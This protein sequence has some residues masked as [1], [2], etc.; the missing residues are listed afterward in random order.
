MSSKGKGV[1]SYLLGW[2]GGLITLFAFKD[3]NR[4]DVFHACQAI[5]ISVAQLAA[6]IVIAVISAVL[7]T[8]TG[9]S[10]GFVGWIIDILYC[11]LVILGLVKVLNDE[12]DPKLPV[13]GDIT[14]KIFEKKINETPE[15]APAAPTA[16]FDP[17]TGQ[18]INQPQANFD[19]NTGQPINQPTPESNMGPDPDAAPEEPAQEEAPA[20]AA[21]PAEEL[22]DDSD[23]TI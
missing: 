21:E 10:L 8:V 13:V 14:E 17:N 2:V 4:K 19:P 11:I 12:A 7:A 20:D 6:T 1:L 9:V 22:K 23:Q 3:N 5:T 16:N 18:P 15:A